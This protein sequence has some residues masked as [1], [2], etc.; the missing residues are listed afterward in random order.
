VNIILTVTFTV[1]LYLKFQRYDKGD[2]ACD[3]H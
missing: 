1:F 3:V 2:R